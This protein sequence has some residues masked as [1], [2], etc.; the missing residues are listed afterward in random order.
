VPPQSGCLATC[1]HPLR[2]GF[3]RSLRAPLTVDLDQGLIKYESE[4]RVQE[5]YRAVSDVHWPTSVGD[6]SLSRR[7]G[8]PWYQLANPWSTAQLAKPG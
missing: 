6:S 4:R 5:W 8:Q 7:C 1:V 3:L 2:C